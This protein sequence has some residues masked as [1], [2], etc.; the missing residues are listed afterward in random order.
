MNKRLLRLADNPEGD[1]EESLE[2]LLSEDEGDDD[3]DSA[4]SLETKV[5]SL[6]K[7]LREQATLML[8]LTRSMSAL[9]KHV[10]ALDSDEDSEEDEEAPEEDEFELGESATESDFSPY[11]DSD[12]GSPESYS[13]SEEDTKNVPG[14]VSMARKAKVDKDD[15]SSNFG[16]KDS[17]VPGNPPITPD[18]K[19]WPA[20][21]TIIPKSKMG[22]TL[23]KLFDENAE[24]KA[25]LVSAGIIKKA[26][27][28]T[29]G[30]TPSEPTPDL[31]ELEDRA[32][33]MSFQE[34]NR[35]RVA[36]GDL[37]DSII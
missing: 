7:A 15:A 12:L 27:G 29:V 32:R 36:V 13:G 8:D 20:D 9:T 19:D 3:E 23:K 17:D 22:P 11:G 28:P 33:G 5:S 31:G 24:I 34:I 30:K 6:S 25:A 21:A 14:L 35:F 2:S 18:T 37:P 10:M 26:V 16:E 4:E 1:D